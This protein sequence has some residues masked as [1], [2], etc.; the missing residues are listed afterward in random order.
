MKVLKKLNHENVLALEHFE[1]NDRQL[2]VITEYCN[3]G[4]LEQLIAKK[5]K[6]PEY[7]ALSIL[8]DII[9]G[10]GH[11]AANNILHRD[12]KPANIFMSNGRA[13]LADFG[14][15]M[16]MKY[17]YSLFSD[18]FSKEQAVGSPLYMPP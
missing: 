4:D 3:G 17:Q 10:Y 8:E 12:I 7:L 14:F 1:E 13:K 18:V 15:A 9:K 5:K 11:L 16:T 6:L 2:C